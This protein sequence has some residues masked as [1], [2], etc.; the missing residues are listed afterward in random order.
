MSGFKN[1]GSA[2]N[3]ML[4]P[5]ENVMTSL[6]TFKDD[7]IDIAYGVLGD[8]ANGIDKSANRSYIED[9]FIRNIKPRNAEILMQQPDA[10]VLIKKRMFTSLLS[11]YKTELLNEDEKLFIKA[12]KILFKNKCALIS[13]YEKLC[14]LDRVIEDTGGFNSYMLPLVFD[15]IDQLKVINEYA[16]TGYLTYGDGTGS[17]E[18]LK[19]L[20]RQLGKGNAIF[21]APSSLDSALNT[22]KDLYKFSNPN[23][24]TTWI[25]NRD[26]SYSSYIGEGTGVIELTMFGSLSTSVGLALGDGNASFDLEDPYKLMI[27]TN[28]EIDAAIASSLNLFNQNNFLDFS[29]TELNTKIEESKIQLN[30]ARSKRKVP[31]ISFIVDP[32]PLATKTI[33]TII[34]GYTE[35]IFDYDSGTLGFN[36]SVKINDEFLKLPMGLNK[37]IL[38]IINPQYPNVPSQSSEEILFKKIISDTYKLLKL[39]ETTRNKV[40]K[41]NQK[42]NYVRQKMRLHFANKPII[43]PRDSVHIYIGSKTSID[44]KISSS[45]GPYSDA[46]SSF[47]LMKMM[48]SIGNLSD[49]IGSYF[50]KSYNSYIEIEKNAIAGEGF[51]LW[52]YKI[53]RNDFTKESA[54]T[55]VFAGLVESANHNYS[56][57]KYTLQVSVRDNSTYFE[58]SIVNINPSLDVFNY[59]LYDPLTPFDIKF[60]ASSGF[61]EG[62]FPKLLSEN[63]ELLNK[64]VLR[65]NNGPSRGSIV[66]L[67]NFNTPEQEPSKGNFRR[68]INAPPGLIYRWKQGIGTLTKNGREVEQPGFQSQSQPKLTNQPFAGQDAMNVLSLLITGQPYNF[69]NFIR[70]AINSGSLSRDDLNNNDGTQ[71]YFR[72]LIDD[73]SKQNQIWGNFIP[74]KKLVLNQAAYQFIANGQE[75][76]VLRNEKLQG[77]IQKRAELFDKLSLLNKEFATNPQIFDLNGFEDIAFTPAVSKIRKKTG[78]ETPLLQEIALLDV[79]INNLQ[80]TSAS[81]LL[82]PDLFQKGQ[83][84]IFGNDFTLLDPNISDTS[85]SINQDQINDS[86]D[87]LR[88]N[89]NALTMRRSWKVRSNR[90]INL[91]IVDDTYDKNYDIQ[92]FEQSFSNGTFNN[93]FNSD[94]QTVLEQIRTISEISIGLEIYADTQ[95]HIQARSPQYN[96]MPKSVFFKMFQSK[97]Q[98]GVQIFP[99]F[100]ESL[101]VNQIED[102][103]QQIE[104]IEL[105]IRLRA[106]VLGYTTDTTAQQFLT[107]KNSSPFKFI[108]DGEGANP[109]FSISLGLK[110]IINQRNV[111]N[112]QEFTKELVTKTSTGDVTSKIKSSINPNVIFSIES[113]INLANSNA[114][115]NPKF[116][117]DTYGKIQLLRENI[118]SR[119]KQPAPNIRDLISSDRLD[120]GPFSQST[121]VKLINELSQL[122][123]Q[124][125]RLLIVMS[126]SLK[127]LSEGSELNLSSSEGVRSVLFPQS[128]FN[129]VPKILEHMIEDEDVDDLGPGSGARYIIKDYQIKSFSITEN[130]PEYTTVQVNGLFDPLVPQGPSGLDIGNNGSAFTSALAV[131]YD[132]W[133][134]Y[135]FTKAASIS[136]PFFTDP[137]SQCAPFAVYLLNRQRKKIFTASL[138]IVGNEYMQP[139]EVVYIEDRDLLF[140]VKKVNHSFSYSGNSFETRLDLE[141]GHNPGEYIPTPLDIIGKALY[142]NRFSANE[143][144]I[145][146][147]E[148]AN[149][150]QFLN[151]IGI[152]IP[153]NMSDL[154]KSGQELLNAIT[155]SKCGEDN[156]NNLIN[157]INTA[158]KYF[159]PNLNNKIATMQLRY[160]YNTATGDSESQQVKNLANQLL[161]WFTSPTTFQTGMSKK[162]LIPISALKNLAID[163]KNIQII[164][165]NLAKNSGALVSPSHE[166]HNLAR[167][168]ADNLSPDV[169]LKVL[170]NN[171]IDIVM[172]FEDPVITTETT[173]PGESRDSQ[174]AEIVYKNILNLLDTRTK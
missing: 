163:K 4:S 67:A 146:R 28:D 150:D 19:S 40:R 173:K 43:Q 140:Y 11:N 80:N 168:I 65:I 1:I 174:Y 23:G 17:Q 53:L 106:A 97:Q 98:S 172:T 115:I 13:A 102:I 74:F 34:D 33:R 5:G 73:L 126:N 119:T 145:D 72:G 76:Y 149:G 59:N 79:S 127:N 167:V 153:N 134:M 101:F 21:G 31:G 41:F 90:D 57:G 78:A 160:Y 56:D 16:S 88:K 116:P 131:D 135:G 110:E 121:I 158:S 15:A 170:Y 7:K 3:A 30:Q 171:V 24:T 165:I 143:F 63:Q 105:N 147:Y 161:D 104:I 20:E 6:N 133:N 107:E 129:N 112:Y 117:S 22:I 8:Y 164:G 138:T 166:A 12:S 71:S 62:K 113:Q 114:T 52:L 35:I 111:E 75:S 18:I 132:L 46:S 77:L 94:Y 66:D 154:V 37:E 130:L 55:H 109:S 144:R 152:D 39:Q 81:Q 61:P 60:N 87:K 100:L 69:I 14:K 83:L 85:T 108:S 2:L 124:R 99:E 51:P 139:G 44:N 58:K 25:T 47:T 9:G 32:N 42:T 96:R 93:I 137:D 141:Y 49:D 91:F 136:A 162:T 29:I 123:S 70:A 36:N 64:G 120:A 92:V 68:V 26:S 148:S 169:Y 82:S 86:Q 103:S 95:G 142:N 156:K 128:T 118:Q 50:N 10:V 159:Q 122:I 157:I 125:Q 27:I 84:K 45:I 151:A 155:N 48:Q 38:P 89:L 54:G